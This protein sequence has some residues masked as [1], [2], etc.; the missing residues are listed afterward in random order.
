MI[1]MLPF[2]EKPG[3]LFVA[4]LGSELP[5]HYVASDP[6]GSGQSPK[7]RDSWP[8]GW[9]PALPPG[10]FTDPEKCSAT[11]L[12]VSVEHVR[13]VDTFDPW[14]PVQEDWAWMFG[15][16]LAGLLQRRFAI[17]QRLAGEINQPPRLMVGWE[18]IDS[19][20]RVIVRQAFLD[21]DGRFRLEQAYP[22]VS[23]QPKRRWWQRLLRIKSPVVVVP[24][25]YPP[26]TV[27]RVGTLNPG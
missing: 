14:N 17:P 27:Y 13:V 9:I 20:D 7:F 25:P 15:R 21:E 23:P 11:R 3:M 18:S 19:K 24:K 5:K 6:P 16:D 12:P 10:L 1:E 8:A 4:P 22:P 2:T 26:F